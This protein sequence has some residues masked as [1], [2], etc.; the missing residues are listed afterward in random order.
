VKPVDELVRRAKEA[1]GAGAAGIAGRPAMGVT[2]I[3]CMDARI[4]PVRLF[5]LELGDAHVLRN[6][7]G[8]VTE[9]VIRSV[10]L[11]QR[12]LGTTDV[13]LVHHTPCGLEGLKEAVTKAEIEAETGIRPPFALEGFEDV[14]ADVRQSMARIRSSPFLRR[15]GSVRGFVY[16]LADGTLREVL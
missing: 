3:T 2:I 12:L 13:V 11:S 8:V 7:G 14:D 9:D 4:D 5:G 10:M 1:G 16:D 6:A 15:D